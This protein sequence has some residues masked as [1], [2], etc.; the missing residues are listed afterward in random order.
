MMNALTGKTRLK[1]TGA[2]TGLLLGGAVAI[3]R[4]AAPAV[5]AVRHGRAFQIVAKGLNNPRSLAWGPKNELLVAEAGA[6]GPSCFGPKGN[7][8][9]VG[10]TGAV[11]GITGGKV[12]TLAS[13]L[14]S[15]SSPGGMEATGPDGLAYSGGHIYTVMTESSA[16]VPA[17][18]PPAVAAQGYSQ[19]GRLL[20]V[21]G[22]KYSVIAD[23]GDYD[24]AWSDLHRS[25]TPTNF[26]D[27]NPYALLM[28]GKAT[29]VVDAASNTLDQVLPDG[30]V[31]I[32]AFVPNTPVGD[33]VP[34][35]VAQGP[36]QNLYIGQ[37]T[38]AGSKAGAANVYKYNVA[39]GKLTVWQKGFTDITGCGFDTSGNFYVTELDLTGFPPTDQ[40]LG[41]AVVQIA[42]NGTRTVIGKG[43]LNAPSGFLAGSGNTIY[44]SNLSVL[45]ANGGHGFPGGEVVKISF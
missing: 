39:T 30:S 8:T 28:T 3:A 16:V 29:Y 13:G 11:A 42:K 19:L 21:S 25:L 26:P 31:K 20:E 12:T 37:L 32:L 41:G 33:A 2:V 23:P 40:T 9:C 14:V 10:L 22:S 27:A 43:E 34:T 24:Y 4:E 45:P 38:P 44:V 15:A 17:G 18:L 5:A 35:C 6:G 1:L 36:D 7:K